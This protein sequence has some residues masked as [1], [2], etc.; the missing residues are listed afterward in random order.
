[1]KKSNILLFL[2]SGLLLFLVACNFGGLHDG[3]MVEPLED[4][5]EETYEDNGDIEAGI[6]SSESTA[7]P[8][9]K[10]PHTKAIKIQEAKY[11]YVVDSA[12]GM[13]GNFQKPNLAK[14][15]PKE[16]QK[17]SEQQ[18]VQ[19]PKPK[20]E[21]KTEPK[22]TPEKQADTNT[23][24]QGNSNVESRVI[25]LTNQERRK[26]GLSD[27]QGDSSLSNVARTKSN[28]MQQNNYFSHTSP[29]YGS[30]FDMIRDFGV[31][32]NSAA[33]NIAKGQQTPEQVVQSWMNSEGHRKNI[34]NGTFTHIG[35]G[36][37]ENGHYWT[38]MFI[39]K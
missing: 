21:P 18:P 19:T 35:I 31:S 15:E 13:Q 5:W 23:Q 20:V 4:E 1:M 9:Q 8:S 14:V 34:L 7:I 37:N 2:I 26:N 38:Q 3:D 27:L 33:E 10:F 30:P 6:I 17:V 39:S 29:S 25:E 22:V 24:T 12:K 16:N 28:D 11:K 32:Y 36:Y